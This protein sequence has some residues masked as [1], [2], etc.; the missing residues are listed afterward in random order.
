MS[1]LRAPLG[2]L[3]LTLHLAGCSDPETV[4]IVG[5]RTLAGDCDPLVPEVCLLPF[6]SDAYR[7]P[8]PSLP[9][10]YRIDLPEAELPALTQAGPW[11][12]VDGY[13]AGV[14]PMTFMPGA[15]VTGLPTHADLARSLDADCPTVLIDAATGE[16]I[17][18]FAELD[19]SHPMDDRRVLMIR[20]VRR[21]QDGTRY[22]VAIR[23]VVDATGDPIP[24][25][26]AF[27]ALR[28][29]APS[30]DVDVTSSRAFFEELF[31]TLAESG[32]EQ[33]SLQ[34]AWDFTT[35]TRENNTG[36]MLHMRDEAL[37]A[38]DAGGP[39]FEDLVV[40]E[41]PDAHTARRIDGQLVVPLYLDKAGTGGV[42]RYDDE[43]RPIQ[44]GEARYPFLV[45]IPN[46]ALTSPKPPL[47]IGHG[48]LGS[49]EQARGFTTFADEQGYVLFAMDWVGM[50]SDDVAT[51]GGMLLTG[52]MHLFQ[53]IPDRL[54]QG[55]LNLLL[56]TRMM[57]GDLA[58][59]PET[60]IAGNATIDPSEPF[61]YGGSQGGIFGAS[62]MAIT[63]DFARGV[64][65]VPG[66]P[67]SLLLNRS[68]DF[69]VYLG[70]LRTSVPDPIEVQITL[71]LAQ[72]LWD[73]AE[74]NGY[75]AY[76][77]ENMLPGTPAHEVLL[78]D[79]L[80]DHQVSTLG[81]HV[82]A[83]S[84]GATLI[85]PALR[86]VFE[87]PVV[88]SPHV[89]SALVEFDFGNAPDPVINVPPSDGED[90][91]GKLGDV[92]AATELADHFLKT[93]EVIHTCNNTCNPD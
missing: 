16:R 80:G 17:P 9:S 87:L 6:P 25:S 74:P 34:I 21:L 19:E 39:R 27:A 36:T 5:P 45:L 12:L 57:T 15:T 83:R 23:G 33:D 30:N 18:H 53:A 40:T 62:V 37:A 20:P 64:L 2:F 11:R 26:P 3:L 76:I 93:G 58:S 22:I 65:A 49:R 86:E 1:L 79:A 85:R 44:N 14:A 47:A 13:S 88:D 66:Q 78:L 38:L 82:M 61:Y 29:D 46:S 54:Q 91:H 41:N 81:A 43:G 70:L 92:P 35:A 63:T 42:I 77:R 55:F 4:A 68:V 73:R 71:G 50:A 69:D 48:L 24:P 52:E 31:A 90:P 7:R 56:A 84:I 72:M 89:G 28:D 60:T 75:S 32:V 10:G 59:A 67:Y 51:I 8:D